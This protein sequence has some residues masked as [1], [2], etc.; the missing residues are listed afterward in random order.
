MIVCLGYGG[1]LLINRSKSIEHTKTQYQL[2]PE[3][4]YNGEYQK[5]QSSGKAFVLLKK[6]WVAFIIVFALSCLMVDTEYYKGLTLGF[7]FMFAGLLFIDTF[8]HNRLI[9][10]LLEI[11][12]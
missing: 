9:Q 11:N 8:L 5:G 4:T 2:H 7:V 12:T 10:Y 6:I 1:Y 3:E